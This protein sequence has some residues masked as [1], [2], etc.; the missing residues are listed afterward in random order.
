MRISDWSSDVCSSDLRVDP[1]TWRFTLRE[2]VKFHDGADFD[3]DAAARSI[4]RTM[5][6]A[7]KSVVEGKGVSVRVDRGGRRIIKKNKKTVPPHLVYYEILH[8][9]RYS[10][11]KSTKYNLKRT[12]IH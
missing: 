3:A 10:I 1:K 11:D 7:R 9:N 12:Q 4:E 8:Q 2:G 5:D 6:A